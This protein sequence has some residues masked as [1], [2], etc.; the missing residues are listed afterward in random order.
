MAQ[1]FEDS[2]VAAF[3]HREQESSG[4][5]SQPVPPQFAK[6]FAIETL[7]KIFTLWHGICLRPSDTW[8]LGGEMYVSA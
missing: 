7:A 4:L 3:A 2:A 5:S 1:K 6:P 8:R